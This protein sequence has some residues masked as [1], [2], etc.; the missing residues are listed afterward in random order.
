MV[1][2]QSPTITLNRDYYHLL[3]RYEILQQNAP[4][5]FLSSAKPYARLEVAAFADSLLASGNFTS[6]Q[7]QFNLMYL[8]NDNWEFAN[9]EDNLSK[10]PF[11]KRFYKNKTDLWSIDDKDAV[12]RVNP[13]YYAMIG[14]DDNVD[15][16]PFLHYRGAEVRTV[17]GKKLAIQGAITESQSR[18]P[19][20]TE[21]YI[22]Q[23]GAIPG[24]GF[25]KA[26]NP[27]DPTSKGKD[28]FNARASVIFK[29]FEF[30]Q[31]QFGHDRHFIGNGYRSLILSDFAANY[32]FLRINTRF[33]KVNYTN[34]FAEMIADN[35]KVTGG[36]GSGDPY[37]K[38]YMAFHHLGIDLAPNFNIG[39][40][41]SVMFAR[42]SLGGG[43]FDWGYLNP[44]V[45]Y[46]AI[47]HHLGDPDN[48]IIGFD[49]KWNL[50]KRF[51]LYGQVV[52]DE[53]VAKE[54]AARN[55]WWGNKQALQ[56]GGKYIN[57]AGINN[58]DLQVELNV[59]RPF[60]YTH[61][62][63]PE[64]SNYQHYDQP[65]AHPLGANFYELIGIWRYQPIP[66]LNLT[67]KTFY[68][69]KGEDD[70][71]HNYGGDIFK[72]YLTRGNSLDE[73]PQEYGFK[74]AGG[75]QATRLFVDFTASYQLRHNFFIDLR[76]IYRNYQSDNAALDFTT[77]FSSIAF[78]LNIAQELHE[79]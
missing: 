47:E 62:Q 38:K 75:V 67:L 19:L 72:D 18:Y 44:V 59:V 37:P 45:F 58:L 16:N 5:G 4:A 21:Q 20:F 41:E 39:I 34:I 78:R 33:W 40:F 57:V 49:F 6:R 31:M 35:Q 13:I 11:L 70:A 56:L 68:S 8:L 52:I 27:D 77:N 74:L 61:Y 12:I 17:I 7:D 29:P 76:H 65:L 69:K 32:T 43:G 66:R 71:T 42:D 54:V 36:G 28:F 73:N 63:N 3:D 10:K 1:V 22:A 55:Q 24:Q 14:Q 15:K 53:F 30:M 25:Y 50:W 79:Y 46:R 51:Q 2:G 60:T 23:R 26:L 64:Y 9:Q 48:V